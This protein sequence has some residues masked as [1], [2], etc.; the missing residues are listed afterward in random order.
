MTFTQKQKEL[1]SIAKKKG[2]VTHG[3]VASVFSSPI[4]RK[5]NLE[6]FIALKLLKINPSGTTYA[7]DLNVL[8]EIEEKE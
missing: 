1:L 2:Y 6:R 3:D 8:K 7:L 5:S 4:A